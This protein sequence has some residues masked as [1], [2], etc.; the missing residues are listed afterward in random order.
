MNHDDTMLRESPD[1][2]G[3][4]D[5]ICVS[6]PEMAN[7]QRREVAECLQALEGERAGAGPPRAQGSLVRWWRGS[8]VR[9]LKALSC[10]LWRGAFAAR[11]LCISMKVLSTHS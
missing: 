6:C 7:P 4:V 3:S 10:V 9:L 1:A 8:A 11:G 2:E 5:S